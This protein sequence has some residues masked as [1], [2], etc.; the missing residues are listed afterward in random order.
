MDIY[1]PVQWIQW[2]TPVLIPTCFCDGETGSYLF[3]GPRPLGEVLLPPIRAKG[4]KTWNGKSVA[5]QMGSCQAF[6]EQILRFDTDVIANA[7]K[8]KA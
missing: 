5:V 8:V 6:A 4:I 1:G 3:F 2:S 7:A